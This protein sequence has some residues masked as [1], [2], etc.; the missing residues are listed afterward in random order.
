MDEKRQEAG[1]QVPVEATLDEHRECM[2]VVAEVEECLDRHPD[3]PGPWVSDLRERLVRLGDTLRGHFIEEQSGPLYRGLPVTHPWLA[4]RLKR[5]EAEHEVMLG[6]VDSAVDRAG[7][8]DS[9]EPSD[10]REFNAR[11]QLL[12]AR[13][14]RHEAEENEIVLEAH[15]GEVGVGD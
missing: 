4:A 2:A 12:V 5:L 1:G 14:H 6:A 3:P 7:E 13:I 9:P 10:V 15:W 11:I 8:L